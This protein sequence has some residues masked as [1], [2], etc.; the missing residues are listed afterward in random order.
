MSRQIGAPRLGVGISLVAALAVVIIGLHWAARF[1]LGGPED[2]SRDGLRAWADD[3][4]VVVATVARWIALGLAYYLAAVLIVLTT[5]GDSEK[6]GRMVPRRWIAPLAAA[7]G[8]GVVTMSIA[9][10][11]DGGPTEPSVPLTLQTSS[12]PLVLRPEAPLPSPAPVGSVIAPT[13]GAGNEIVTPESTEVVPASGPSDQSVVVR[14]GDSFWA[15]AA[16]ELIEAWGRP[17]TDAEIV[18]YWHTMIDANR[19]RLVEPGNP[20]L[21]LPGQELAVPLVPPDP[22]AG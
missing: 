6:V 10:S 13:S 9:S 8:I 17:V 14:P 18:P 5:S 11:G 15:L 21:I 4:L 20:D 7:L 2:W 12:A 3:P 19:D 16:E 22:R 1:D